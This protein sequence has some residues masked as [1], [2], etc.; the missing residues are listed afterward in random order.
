MEKGPEAHSP[1]TKEL[2]SMDVKLLSHPFSS[3]AHPSQNS[4][5]GEVAYWV[6]VGHWTVTPYRSEYS[7]VPLGASQAAVL[8]IPELTGIAQDENQLK[9][10][11]K[12]RT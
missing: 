3:Q 7:V 5:V 10:E 1:S 8:Q 2:P 9:N 12:I 11:L 6:L 4:W